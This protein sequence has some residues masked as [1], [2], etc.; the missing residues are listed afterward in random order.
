[1]MLTRFPDEE[2]YNLGIQARNDKLAKGFPMTP[3]KSRQVTPRDRI[4][5][6]EALQIAGYDTD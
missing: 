3:E 1:M 6:R 4:R 5:I 2:S